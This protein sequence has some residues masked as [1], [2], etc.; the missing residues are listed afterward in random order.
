MSGFQENEEASP[1]E[2]AI[3][4]LFQHLDFIFSFTGLRQYKAKFATSWEPRYVVYRNVFDLPGYARAIEKL[5]ETQS[6]RARFFAEVKADFLQSLRDD[7]RWF[8]AKS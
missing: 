3:H 1:E 8:R 4:Y 7:L 5:S 2:K 6:R